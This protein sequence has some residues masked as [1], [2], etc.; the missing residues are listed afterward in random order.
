MNHD[1]QPPRTNYTFHIQSPE[2]FY[3][4]LYQWADKNYPET[5]TLDLTL[6]QQLLES[7]GVRCE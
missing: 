3:A 4:Q 1:E 6:A 7:I 5:E 2:D